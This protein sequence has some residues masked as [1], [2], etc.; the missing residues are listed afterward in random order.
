MRLFLTTL[1]VSTLALSPLLPQASAI[2][3]SRREHPSSS[4]TV[5]SRQYRVPRSILDLCINAN[6]DL[7]AD[8]SQLLGLV[9]ILGSVNLGSKIQLCLC[10]KVS[11]D[12]F[13]RKY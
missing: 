11:I 1:F 12:N 8:A 2:H 10:L 7:L 5:S 3:P 6:V 9:P 13:S 4:L